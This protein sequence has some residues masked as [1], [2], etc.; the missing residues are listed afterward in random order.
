MATMAGLVTY[1][2]IKRRGRR[3]YRFPTA[4]AEP[5]KV[6]GHQVEI[7]TFG[8]DLYAAMISDIE[9]AQHT[10]YLETFIWK[11]NDEVGRHFRQAL[12]EAA[13]RG[14]KVYAMWDTFANLVV[15]P[16]FFR[17][18]EGVQVRAQPLVTP[19]WIPT[20]RNLGRDHRKLLIVDSKVAYIGGTTSAPST[21][22]AGVMP[23]LVLPGLPS[24]SSKTSLL[25]CGINAP[26]S[27]HLPAQP[28]RTTL[29]RR[30]LL[31]YPF[32]RA[33]QLPPDGG[34]SH[35]EYV[36]GGHRSRE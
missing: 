27:P 26:R 28:A 31:G 23:T 6:S 7:F 29:S 10:V 8:R 13:A 3:P 35:P 9:S 30:P 16:R 20:L 1:N 22:T 21:P 24:G 33:P 12:V 36:P 17:Q 15:D 25:T 2:G 18:L 19:S 4:P 32:R 14:V 5:L 11:K 34:L